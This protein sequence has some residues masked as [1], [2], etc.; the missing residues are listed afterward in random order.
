MFVGEAR[1]APE[2]RSVAPIVQLR[3]RSADPPEL[4]PSRIPSQTWPQDEFGP[5]LHQCLAAGRGGG[6][7]LPHSHA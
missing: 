1:C 6:C 2:S 5:N 7:I 4:T 3:A